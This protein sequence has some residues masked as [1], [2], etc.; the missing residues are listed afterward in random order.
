MVFISQLF[1]IQCLVGMF[2][3]ISDHRK[4]WNHVQLR[5][6]RPT[7]TYF[8]GQ[9]LLQN[10]WSWTLTEGVSQQNV[11]VMHLLVCSVIKRETECQSLPKPRV[12][13]RDSLHDTHSDY[14]CF[15]CHYSWNISSSEWYIL[16][17]MSWIWCHPETCLLMVL[18]RLHTHTSMRFLL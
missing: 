2:V 13:C 3:A 18:V 12:W 5:C 9:I 6:V 8:K 14:T 7:W 16:M 17:G 1:C 4:I 10:K 11:R 15:K